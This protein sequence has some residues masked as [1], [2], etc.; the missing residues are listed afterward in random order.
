M[1]T[2]LQLNKATASYNEFRT[3]K[4][5]EINDRYFSDEMSIETTIKQTDENGQEKK[6][7]GRQVKKEYMES[8]HKENEDL[9]AQLL[10]LSAEKVTVTMAS[11]D[12]NKEIALLEEK[13]DIADV[14]I[15]MDDLDFLDFFTE[16]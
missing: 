4:R 14:D 16:K 8:F 2:Y 15:N 12:V 5:Q 3:E 9:I 13:G 6:V 1:I 10:Q 11:I 7:P